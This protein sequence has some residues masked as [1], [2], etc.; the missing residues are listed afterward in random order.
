MSG[1]INLHG[2]VLRTHGIKEKVLLARRERIWNIILPAE[3]KPDVDMLN[4]SIKSG[5]NFY[6]VSEFREVYEL[7]FDQFQPSILNLNL[8]KP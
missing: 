3:N 8:E 2:K 7:L 5:F 6:F 4:D 1:E